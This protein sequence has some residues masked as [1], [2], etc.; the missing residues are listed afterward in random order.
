MTVPTATE[1]AY[2]AYA[3]GTVNSLSADAGISIYRKVTEGGQVMDEQEIARH[4][5]AGTGLD[6]LDGTLNHEAAEAQIARMGYR[7]TSDWFTSGGG[8]G[9]FVE[10]AN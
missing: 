6:R 5:A 10:V 4:T 3:T 9:A 7:M 1:P 8:E 2:V